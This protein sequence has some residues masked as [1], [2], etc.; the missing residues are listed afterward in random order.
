[1]RCCICKTSE[2][3]Q[4][5]NVVGYCSYRPFSAWYGY[6][7]TVEN[8]IYVHRD[9]R[10]RGIARK[11]LTELV[12]QANAQKLHTMITGIEAEN[13]ASLLLHELMG[14]EQ[15]AHLHEVVY[16]FGR[17]LDLVLMELRL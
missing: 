12:V 14:L 4:A 5:G 11:I 2:A 10:R 9:C 8:S 6:R 17:W 7:F 1:V 16:K 13:H 15:A 3:C